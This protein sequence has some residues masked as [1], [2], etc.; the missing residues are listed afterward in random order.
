MLH[1]IQRAPCG[2]DVKRQPTRHST[3]LNMPHLA[4]CAAACDNA[5]AIIYRETHRPLRLLFET[6]A[7]QVSGLFRFPIIGLLAAQFHSGIRQCYMRR[8][9]YKDMFMLFLDIFH[10]CLYQSSHPVNTSRPHTTQ[11]DWPATSIREWSSKVTI[12][13]LDLSSRC[14]SSLA[15]FSRNTIIHLP[16]E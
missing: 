5:T 8:T 13:K 16:C 9:L 1:A 10:R 7:I 12:D 3:D 6:T 11:N 14:R 4:Y 15:F 2:D